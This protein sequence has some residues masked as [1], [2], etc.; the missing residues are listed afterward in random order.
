MF[1]DAGNLD[2]QPALAVI[3]EEQGFGAALAL[4]VA[5]ADA[6]R[7][8]VAPIILGLRMDRGVAIYFAGR[9]LENADSKA[10]G[11]AEQVDRAMDRRLGRLDGIV[12]VMD[13]RG[14]TGEVVD[15]VDFDEQREGDV[16]AH[17]L[18][19]RVGE[20]VRDIGLVAGE[21]ICRRK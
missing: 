10:L 9:G 17:Q 8:D 15:F 1:E 5:G 18:E 6:D 19:F 7:I 12:L 4:V 14:G 11:E 16:V 3:V 2:L 21:E 13:R 20:E